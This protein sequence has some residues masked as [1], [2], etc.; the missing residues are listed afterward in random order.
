MGIN[1]VQFQRGLPMA[2]FMERYGTQEQCHA[3]LV[4]SRWPQGFV[5]SGCGATRHST[6]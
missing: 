1:K 4:A 6:F 3:A 5:C 2:E